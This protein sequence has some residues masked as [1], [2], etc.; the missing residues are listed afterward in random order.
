MLFVIKIQRKMPRRPRTSVQEQL[1]FFVQQIEKFKNPKKTGWLFNSSDY[2]EHQVNDEWIFTAFLTFENKRTN[3]ETEWE[4]IVNFI[5]KI[6]DSNKFNIYPWKLITEKIDPSPQFYEIEEQEAKEVTT[7]DTIP[8]VHSMLPPE[9]AKTIEDL[10]EL[11]P[12]ELLKPAKESDRLIENHP[13]FKGIYDRGPQIRTC[14]SAIQNFIISDG[15]KANHVLLYGLPACAK[16]Q[17]LLGI[18]KLFGPGSVLK[19]DSTSTTR[20]GLERLI[21]SELEFIPP[22]IFMEEIEKANE[23]ALRI[24]LGVNQNHLNP[25]K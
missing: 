12:H 4:E 8:G 5:Q 16:T 21:F 15:K 25:K 17:I 2:N 9:G 18:E 10:K 6:G 19:L 3:K 22:L 1:D 13:A 20:A 24:W 14:L 7:K 11:F 23:E